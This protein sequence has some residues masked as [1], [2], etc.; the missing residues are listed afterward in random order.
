MT[1]QTT[2]P[3]GIQRIESKGAITLDNIKP[4]QFKVDLQGNAKALSA[5]IR[6]IFTVV[7]KYPS[8]KIDSDMQDNLFSALEFGAT[9]QD[10]TSKEQRVAWIDVPLKT[11]E[12]EMKAK[13]VAANTAGAV[14]YKVLSNAPIFDS[15]QKAGINAGLTTEDILANSQAIRYPVGHSQEGQ[16]IKD[17]RSNVQYRRTFFSSKPHADID[18][19]DGVDVYVTPEIEAELKGASIMEGQS[20]IV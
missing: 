2:V 15:N 12:D 11:T 3:Q 20:L 8:M 18:V 13:L 10:F 19:R 16:L 9:T 6:Q 17:K 1:N 14:I 7:S 4:S 5:Q